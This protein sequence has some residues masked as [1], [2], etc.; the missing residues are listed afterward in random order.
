VWKVSRVGETP[1]L[2]PFRPDEKRI[3]DHGYNSP[4][5][6]VALAL[7]LSQRGIPAVYPRAIYMTGSKSDITREL[8]DDR[9]YQSH[10]ELTTPA[11]HPIL[12]KGRNYII[13]WGFWNGPDELLAQRDEER[14]RGVS[15]LHA[16]REG[17]VD[18]QTY[19]RVMHVARSLLTEVGIEDLNLRG[20][21]LLLSLTPEGELMT[22]PDHLPTIRI[23]NFEL[24]RR[25][26]GGMTV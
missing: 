5:E 9:R 8:S 20:N 12:R 16:C 6:E 22:D 23:C 11:G 2:D 7:E 24:L 15:A 4:F 25:I 21:H 1:D 14:C 10:A 3:L 26:R 13:L 17:I 19:L 18:E